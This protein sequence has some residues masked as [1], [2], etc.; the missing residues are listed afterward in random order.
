MNLLQQLQDLLWSAVP[1]IVLL[2]FLYFFLR[3]TFFGPL[4]KVMAERD[5]RSAGARREAEAAQAAAAEKMHAWQD[6]LKKARL[7]I[8]ANQDAARRAALEERAALVRD[9]RARL[10]EE[11]RAAKEVLAGDV[12]RARKDVESTAPALA[13]EM[14]RA[15]LQPRSGR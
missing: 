2:I 7:D 8:Y 12:Q 1:A 6:A 13:E 10:Q 9:T 11:V 3:T 5:A 4:E 15:I 14:V